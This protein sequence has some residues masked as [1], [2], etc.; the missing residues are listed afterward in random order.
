MIKIS[1]ISLHSN[2]NSISLDALKIPGYGT[3][4]SASATGQIYNDGNNKFSGTVFGGRYPRGA[5]YDVFGGNIDYSNRRGDTGKITYSN[6]PMINRQQ[7]AAEG[8][9][10]LYKT[11]SSS[12][13]LSGSYSRDIGKFQAPPNYGFGLNYN[14]RF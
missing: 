3:I 12:L 10:N 7:I 8:T 5:P 2:G 13:G 9:Y 1:V 14:K 11:P 4:K 6:T